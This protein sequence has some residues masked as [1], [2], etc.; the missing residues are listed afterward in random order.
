[1]LFFCSLQNEPQIIIA[2]EDQEKVGFEV[3]R[4]SKL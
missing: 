4:V 2:D 1:M 3:L